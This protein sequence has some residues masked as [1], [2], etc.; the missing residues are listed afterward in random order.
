MPKKRNDLVL[1]HTSAIFALFLLWF[2]LIFL[3]GAI[4]KWENLL[5]ILLIVITFGVVIA[6]SLLMMKSISAPTD[7]EQTLEK[8]NDSER[9]TS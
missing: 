5:F 9:E 7:S 4:G 6:L 8:S 1:V 2:L 3:K